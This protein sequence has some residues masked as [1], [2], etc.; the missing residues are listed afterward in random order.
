MLNDLMWLGLDWDEGWISRGILFL[1]DFLVSLFLQNI[2]S[3]NI[4]FSCTA[5][6]IFYEFMIFYAQF[7]RK[8]LNFSIFSSECLLHYFWD[9][10][11]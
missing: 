9:G 6:P 5:V 10:H 1:D 4:L 3:L 11:M 7:L 8:E 2:C